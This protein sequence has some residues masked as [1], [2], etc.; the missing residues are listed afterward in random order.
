M[1]WTL[2]DYPNTWKNLDKL[3][4]KKAIDIGNAMLKDGYD[5]GTLIPIATKQA[6]E[7]YQ[8][9]SKEELDE[10]KHK[11]IT[12]HQKDK[13]V[14]PKLNE[15]DVEVYQEDNEWKVKTYGAKQAADTYD[16]KE[17]AVKRANEIAENRGTKVHVKS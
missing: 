13:D 5:E 17:E 6:E 9:A 14:R 12:K 1:P 4:R 10:L 2:D 7:W 3:E 11:N 15:K 8:N 16:K